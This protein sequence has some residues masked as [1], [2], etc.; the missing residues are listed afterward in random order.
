MGPSKERGITR[1]RSRQSV[2]LY[3]FRNVRTVHFLTRE[4]VLTFTL[5]HQTQ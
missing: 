3:Q 5:V 4:L 1:R 2:A